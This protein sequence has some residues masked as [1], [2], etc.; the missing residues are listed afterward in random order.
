MVI[1]DSSCGSLGKAG[2]GYPRKSSSKI[3]KREILR[4][5][6]RM[7]I[8]NECPNFNSLYLW[9]KLPIIKILLTTHLP[10]WCVLFGM[11]HKWKWTFTAQSWTRGKF[12]KW[13][14]ANE[15]IWHGS[16][17][18][19]GVATSP[20]PHSALLQQVS[21]KIPVLFD[22]KPW[23]EPQKWRMTRFLAELATKQIWLS[24]GNWSVNF[25]TKNALNL[26]PNK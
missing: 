16:H 22:N 4:D 7:G 20:V 11:V 9:P 14:E 17:Y 15:S 25:K 24:N 21:G 2:G 12:S 8:L 19:T 10:I 1:N 5:L 13:P 18:L 6:R 23:G 3:N 26:W